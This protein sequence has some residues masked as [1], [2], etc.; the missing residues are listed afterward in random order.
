MHNT[1]HLSQ[2]KSRD[3]IIVA[4]NRPSSLSLHFP[5][6][7]NCDSRKQAI[8]LCSTCILPLGVSGKTDRLFRCTFSTILLVPFYLGPG[9]ISWLRIHRSNTPK[10]RGT[11]KRTLSLIQKLHMLPV[12][13]LKIRQV[14]IRGMSAFYT[15]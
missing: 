1:A 14:C 3:L 5:L 4:T 10:P 9:I 15:R 8:T 7:R 13:G 2:L 11:V 6:N 12:G